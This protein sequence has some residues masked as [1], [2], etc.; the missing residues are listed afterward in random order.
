[1]FSPN[2]SRRRSPLLWGALLGALFCLP[3]LHGKEA[4]DY[5]DPFIGTGHMG[6]D[7]PGATVPFSMVKLSPDCGGSISYH[8]SSNFIQGFSFTHLGGADG[9][10]LGNVLVSPT[11]GPLRVWGSG[12]DSYGSGFSKNTEQATAGYYAVTL[13]DPNVRAEMTVAPHSGI[14]RFTFPENAQS[15]IQIDLSHRNGGTSLHQTYKR[16]DD[17]TIEGQVDYTKAGGGW[18]S[19]YTA[20]YRLEFSKPIAQ[21]GVWSAT[22]PPDWSGPKFRISRTMNTSSAPYVAACKAAQV[23]PGCKEMEG[24]HLGFYDEFPTKAGETVLVKAGISFVSIAGARANLAAEIPDWDF[25]KIHQQA[26]AAWSKE[27]GRLA[28]EGGT[29]D[30][31]TIYYS[32]LYRALQFPQ[33]DQDVDGNYP[34]G[35]FKPHHADGFTNRTIFSG[36]DVYRSEFP[37]LTLIDP[38]VVNDQINSMVSLAET[39]GTH[40]YDRWEIMGYYSGIMIGNPEV[41]IIND[42]YQKGIRNFDVATAYQD[43]VNSVQK[44]GFSPVGYNPGNISETTEYGLDDWNLAQLAQALGKKDDAAKYQQLVSS[45]KKIFDPNQAWTYDAAGTDAKPDWKG[46]FRAR[47]AQGNFVP[48][49]GLLEEKTTREATV[50]QAGWTVYYDVPGMIQLDGGNDLFVAKLTDFFERTPDFSTWSP[51]S[52]TKNPYHQKGQEPWWNS[53]N[54]PVNEPTELISLLFNRAGA[55]WLTQ[56]WVRKSQQVYLTGPEGMPGDDDCGQM[57]AWYVLAAIGLHQLCEGDPRFEVF[58]PMFDKVTLTLDPKYAKGGTFTITTKNQSPENIYIQSARLNGKP[59][60]RCWLNY[61]E[62]AAGGTLNLVLGPRPNKA[63][64]VEAGPTS[65]SL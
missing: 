61:T 38:T 57:S 4:V 47:D 16:V 19:T 40:Y 52:G 27:L 51:Y 53:Y 6:K 26:R 15:R 54:N 22:L 35:D 33:I 11:T 64:G 49:T 55:P 60:N 21:F 25:D 23:I 31:K 24:Q 5:V 28:V 59:F 63:W 9:G 39:N 7:F 44:F 30:N 3:P 32:A 46:W 2:V 42:A 20:Y 17:H 29:E 10:E 37:L 8:Y 45:Y 14:L 48:W 13:N 56:K 18:G 36:W 43:S 41:A 65:P 50:Y 12:K 58:T 62:I 1:M 34:G